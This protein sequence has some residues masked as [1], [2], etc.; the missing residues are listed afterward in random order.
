MSTGTEFAGMVRKAARMS[1]RTRDRRDGGS[2]KKD[3][4]EAIQA[5]NHYPGY[6]NEERTRLYRAAYPV[7]MAWRKH[8]DGYRIDGL[9]RYR[10]DQ[11]TP[12]QFAGLLGEMID[13][14]VTNTFQGELFF[15][16]LRDREA[17]A[18]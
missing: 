11:L 6:Y 8:V 3:I 14:G 15:S 7:W 12:W 9:L 10:I 17:I 4:L 5:S 2:L 16:A 13:A 18:A 1:T